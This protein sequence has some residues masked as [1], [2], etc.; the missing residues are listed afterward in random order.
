MTHSHKEELRKVLPEKASP[1]EIQIAPNP[2][3]ERGRNQAIDECLSALEDKVILKSELLSVNDLEEI[4]REFAN[5]ES[6]KE[7]KQTEW[8]GTWIVKML[9]L[10]DVAQAIHDRLV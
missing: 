5:K 7:E 10:S 2:Q 1:R 3:F 6:A 9:L 8:R 4:I